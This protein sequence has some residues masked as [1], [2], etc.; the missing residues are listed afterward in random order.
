VKFAQRRQIKD[1]RYKDIRK[2]AIQS[3]L[4]RGTYDPPRAHAW[5]HQAN[6]PHINRKHKIYY[7][8]HCIFGKHKRVKFNASVHTTKEI[9]DYVHADVWGLSRKT[10]LCDANYMLTII[11]DYFRKM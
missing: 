9:L 7:P 5:R 3:F 10:S 2:S 6:T 1:A 4:S 11:D 8:E